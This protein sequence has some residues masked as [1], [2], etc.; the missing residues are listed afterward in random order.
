M[1]YKTVVTPTITIGGL[2]ATVGFSGIAPGTGSE[3]QINT[4]I[5]AGVV[6]GDA[7]PVIL[8]FGTSSDTFTIAVK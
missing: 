6:G 5:P 8:T 2:P 7:V 4:V 3:Y 1:I